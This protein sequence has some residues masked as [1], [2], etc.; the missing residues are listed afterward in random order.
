M[1]VAVV[2]LLAIVLALVWGLTTEMVTNRQQQ[3]QI[4]EL[5]SKLGDR[6]TRENLELQEKCALQAER[7]FKRLGYKES[8]PQNG[9]F[10]TYQ[11]HY[12]AKLNKCFMTLDSTTTNPDT[13]FNF[14]FLFDAYEQRGYGEYTK[15]YGEASPTICKL[16][17]SSADESLCTSEEEYK[18]FVARYM[19]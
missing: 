5:T 15:K 12:N 1:K 6:T 2:V 10:G 7:V 3:S 4:T 16:F 18:A 13:E 9:V 14:K 17:P 19:E 11:S 8:V